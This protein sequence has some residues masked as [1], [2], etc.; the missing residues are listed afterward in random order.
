MATVSHPRPA[1]RP[2]L[3]EKVV[4]EG[5]LSDAQLESVILAGQAHERRLPAQVRIGEGWETLQRVDGAAHSGPAGGS[6]ADGNPADGRSADDSP[7]RTEDGE[8][9]S[10]PVRFRRG[11]MLGD[12]TGCGKGRQVAGIILDQWLRGN[13]RAL[14][15]SASDKL[16]EDAR[17]DWAALGGAESDVIP[18]SKF[19]T[20]KAVPR[21]QGILFTTYATLR[22]AA[23]Q[24]SLSRLRQIV[25]WL[26]D[27]LARAEPPHL[28]RRDCVR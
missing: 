18:L 27:G 19:P 22:S 10:S 4:T 11:W 28:L 2:K 1:Y 7:V 17:R 12:G 16:L 6:P 5:R 25:N 24:G 26:A 15:L 13:R 3:P 23:R 14:W 9:F 8:V 21:T 20:G